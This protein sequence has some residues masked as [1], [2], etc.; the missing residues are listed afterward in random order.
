MGALLSLTQSRRIQRAD[1]SFVATD[2]H[3]AE[4]ESW[5]GELVEDAHQRFSA[6]YYYTTRHHTECSELWFHLRPTHWLLYIPAL[7][8]WPER[9]LYSVPLAEGWQVL[10]DATHSSIAA[11]S[12][13]FASKR[14]SLGLSIGYVGGHLDTNNRIKNKNK[15]NM[16]GGLINTSTTSISCSILLHNQAPHWVWWVMIPPALLTDSC[17]HPHWTRDRRGYLQC[18]THSRMAGFVWRHLLIHCNV[19][20]FF[21]LQTRLIGPFYRVYRRTSLVDGGWGFVFVV[22]VLIP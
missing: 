3:W 14:G 12:G 17:L 15:K 5:I 1:T 19:V 4:E 10:F 20:W 2:N 22:S 18:S 7:N 21:R 6:V 13:I 8:P 9:L 16:G 11:W